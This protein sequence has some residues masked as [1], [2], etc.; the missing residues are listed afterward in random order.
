M[1][2]PAMKA[3][4]LRSL[5]RMLELKSSTRAVRPSH[6]IADHCLRHW[7]LLVQDAS[8]SADISSCES[9]PSLRNRGLGRDN[10]RVRPNDT[11]P[12]YLERSRW[13]MEREWRYSTPDAT[14]DAMI[15]F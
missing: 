12:R 2:G 6:R 11:A 3:R 1:L 4:V 14:S 15:N 9:E 13:R 8:W 10:R 7:F 5:R